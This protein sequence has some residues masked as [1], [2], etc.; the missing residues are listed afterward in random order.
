MNY[1]D[2]LAGRASETYTG[3]RYYKALPTAALPSDVAEDT[4]PELFDYEY[5][6]VTSRRYTAIFGNVVTMDAAR[7]AISTKSSIDFTPN[8]YVA[9]KD[10][11][12]YQIEEIGIDARSAPKE[13]ARILLAPVGVTKVLRL[14]RVF[15]AWGIAGGR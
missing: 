6:D 13:A 3:A 14:L 7:T 5:V 15:D 11:Y 1:L 10:G 8:G 12:L 2:I 4:A 9:L